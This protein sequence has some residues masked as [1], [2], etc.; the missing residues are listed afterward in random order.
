MVERV[1]RVEEE[2]C[3]DAYGS[4][5]LELLFFGN[6]DSFRMRVFDPQRC[7]KSKALLSATR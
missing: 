4:F 2:D 6:A 3:V 7:G 5:A 1:L